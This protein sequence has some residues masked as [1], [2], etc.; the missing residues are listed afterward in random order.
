MDQEEA[1]VP[2]HAMLRSFRMLLIRN[3][4]A[5]TAWPVKAK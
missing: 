4:A 3:G 2:A 5:G 1:N